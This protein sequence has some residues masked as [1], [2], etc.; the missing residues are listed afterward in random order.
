MDMHYETNGNRKTWRSNFLGTVHYCISP[1]L[2]DNIL[3]GAGVDISNAGL[4]MF[5]S[6]PLR[7]GQ[8]VIIKNPLPVSRDQAKVRWVQKYS[9]DLFKVGL[10][11]VAA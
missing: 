6:Q 8:A 4:C 10:E 3:L 7:E 5:C 11:F 1:C 9:K 2:D